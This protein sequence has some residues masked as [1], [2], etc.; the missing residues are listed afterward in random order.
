[1][2]QQLQKLTVPAII[3]TS[4]FLFGFIVTA[5]LLDLNEREILTGLIAGLF[6]GVT[7]LATVLHQ[8]SADPALQLSQA[9]T[10]GPMS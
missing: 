3:A 2:L 9:P 6:A 8:A 7:M 5:N 10:T 1:V 4:F